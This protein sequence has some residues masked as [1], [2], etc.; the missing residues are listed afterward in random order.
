MNNLRISIRMIIGFLVIFSFSALVS[1]ICYF[2]FSTTQSLVDGLIQK[3]SKKVSILNDLWV[4][5]SKGSRELSNFLLVTDADNKLEYKTKVDEARLEFLALH[6]ELTLQE[7]SNMLFDSILENAKESF[8]LWSSLTRNA[9]KNLILPN[10][11]G[12]LH[13]VNQKVF[14]TIQ[15]AVDAE[16]Q[17]AK[18]VTQKITSIFSTLYVTLPLFLLLLL[19]VM[20][21]IFFFLTRSISQPIKILSEAFTLLGEGNLNKDISYPYKDEFYP[22]FFQLGETQKKLKSNINEIATV[23][24]ALD[25]VSTNVMI[26]DTDLKIIY[27]NKSVISMFNQA[28]NDIRQRFSDFNPNA[29]IGKSID[30]FHKDPGL[31]RRI[32]SELKGKH[33]ATIHIAGRT[34]ELKANPIINEM[35]DRLGSV[36]EWKDITSQLIVQ[37]EMDDIVTA[38]SQ[39]NFENRINVKNKEGFFLKLSEGINSF[40]QISSKGLQEVSDV[41]SAI[42]NGDLTQKI[43]TE[44]H[45]TFG[46]LKEY[47]NTTVDNLSKI[48]SEVRQ[49]AG[50]LLT[51]AEEVNATAQTLSQSASMQAASVEQ[52]SASLEQIGA[53]ISQNA[54]NSKQTDKIASKAAKDAVEG[55]SSV[56]Q[57]VVA[58]K[59]IAEKIGIVEDISYQTNLLALNAA[60]EAARAGDHGKGFAVVASEVRKLAERSQVAASQI[61][62]LATKSVQV[63]EKTGMLIGEI[64]PSINKT[65][66]LVQEITAATNEQASGVNQINKAIIQLDS[67]S[68]QNASASEELASTAEELSSQAGSLMKSVNFFTTHSDNRNE[69]PVHSLTQPVRKNSSEKKQPV[70]TNLSK[71]SSYQ[72]NEEYERF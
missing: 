23:K 46:E 39:G 40:L 5:H 14:M 62:E 20:V 49:N 61:G 7:P 3:N 52:T 36:V 69:P 28:A 30:Q 27:M 47:C 18:N 38:A 57:T 13:I 44:Y 45:G 67:V 65:A 70:A 71:P 15:K 32:L 1:I 43:R 68:Q 33:D 41:L 66:D 29:L 53:S 21:G 35:N 64:V 60:I 16:Y 19:S 12:N 48:I 25:N 72:E 34:F 22:L 37:K 10:T 17:E 55:G 9:N 42:S 26:A 54:E 11:L 31:Q 24:V 4:I 56:N 8:E 59:Q 51:A 50:S 6:K 2:S 63:A 58:M